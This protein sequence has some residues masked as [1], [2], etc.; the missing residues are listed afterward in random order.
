M[1]E[2]DRFFSAKQITLAIVIGYIILLAVAMAVLYFRT[3][4]H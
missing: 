1:Q 2:L 3:Y 4:A